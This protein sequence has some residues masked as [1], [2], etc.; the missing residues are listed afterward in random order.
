M[1]PISFFKTIA[2]VAAVG[3]LALAETLIDARSVDET[4]QALN[5]MVR[6][7]SSQYQA[8]ASPYLHPMNPRQVENLDDD[9]ADDSNED[10]DAS[11]VDGLSQH[12]A[13]PAAAMLQQAG[14]NLYQNDRQP[15]LYNVEQDNANVERLIPSYNVPQQQQA[16]PTQ[17]IDLK[18]S[19][20][21]HHH[22]HKGAKGW[23]DM[24]AWTGK[25]GAFG[26]YDKHPVGKGK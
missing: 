14:S 13:A 2:V 23:L 3:Y 9:G 10:D 1:S 5:Q 20:S 22:G 19:A 8:G 26:W 24:G 16:Q 6:D 17:H 11:D 25:K 12:N 4:R 21:H 15:V 7:Q 18:T